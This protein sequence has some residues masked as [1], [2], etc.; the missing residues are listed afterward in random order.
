M[1]RNLLPCQ[2][3]PIKPIKWCTLMVCSGLIVVIASMTWAGQDEKLPDSRA[4]AARIRYEK[5]V[6]AARASYHAAV[7]KAE[8]VYRTEVEAAVERATKAGNLDRALKL[9]KAK[10]ELI[11]ATLASEAIDAKTLPGDWYRINHLK[12]LY[13]FRFSPN[14]GVT[15]IE[16][17][18]QSRS[19]AMKDGNLVLNGT[20]VWRRMTLPVFYWRN[21][22]GTIFVLVPEPG[23]AFAAG[24]RDD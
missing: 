4:Q 11:D 20:D 13:H 17:N 7:A 15:P 24:A 3:K 22:E 14:G 19:W 9:R 2:I 16:N 1:T 23:R 21:K 12:D 8:S 6:V 10:K 5:Q 18:S